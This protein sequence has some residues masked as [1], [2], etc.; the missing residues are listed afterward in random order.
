MCEKYF[1]KF[2]NKQKEKR[3]KRHLCKC[4][5]RAF[6]FFNLKHYFKIRKVKFH[7]KKY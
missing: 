6:F 4:K 5:I 7:A 2:K 3:K 1:L